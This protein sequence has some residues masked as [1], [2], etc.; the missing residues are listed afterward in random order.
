MV[1]VLEGKSDEDEACQ[2]KWRGEGNDQEA[3][4][5]LEAPAVPG[6][7]ETSDGIVEV[8]AD[9]FAEDGGDDGGEVEEAW[10]GELSIGGQSRK[11]A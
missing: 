8:V 9:N 6:A 2:H 10:G 3:G 5:G 1:A 4:F 11:T 7:V